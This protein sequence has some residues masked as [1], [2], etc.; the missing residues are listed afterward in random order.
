[1]IS[2]LLL[3]KFLYLCPFSKKLYKSEHNRIFIKLNRKNHEFQYYR[4]IN[5]GICHA[6]A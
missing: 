5:R 3:L 1:M 4:K 2:R 6:Q